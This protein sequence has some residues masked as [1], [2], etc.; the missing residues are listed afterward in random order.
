MMNRSVCCTPRCSPIKVVALWMRSLWLSGFSGSPFRFLLAVVEALPLFSIMVISA[1][2][3]GWES[4]DESWV[5][6]NRS[7]TDNR[8]RFLSLKIFPLV[9]PVNKVMQVAYCRLNCACMRL[10]GFAKPQYFTASL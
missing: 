10:F 1:Q 9:S 8:L 4:T 2:R 7:W 3:P 5:R 6:S